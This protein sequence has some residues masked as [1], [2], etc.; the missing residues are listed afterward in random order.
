MQ[1]HALADAKADRKVSLEKC[2]ATAGADKEKC[3]AA[4]QSK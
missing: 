1:E 3:V 4:V 2:E